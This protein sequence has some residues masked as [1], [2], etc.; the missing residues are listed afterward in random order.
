MQLDEVLHKQHLT[1]PRERI[2]KNIPEECFQ[3]GSI[4]YAYARFLADKDRIDEALEIIRTKRF[5]QFEGQADTR[6]LYVDCL[7]LSGMKMLI[8]E[9]YEGAA[10]RLKKVFEFPENIGSASYL[11]E[12]GRLASFLLGVISF[13]NDEPD[14]TG[15]YW[16]EVLDKQDYSYNGAAF[17]KYKETRADEIIAAAFAASILGEKKTAENL[18]TEIA[19]LRRKNTGAAGTALAAAEQIVKGN[20]I[21]ARQTIK[22]GRSKYCCSNLLKILELLETIVPVNKNGTMI[23]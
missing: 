2:F 18:K 1:A 19:E 5:S 15:N 7:L 12:H 17:R 8:D 9:N 11:G 3:R 4:A 21:K 16:R 10:K 14:K 22:T 23:Y 13:R 20:I 6:R